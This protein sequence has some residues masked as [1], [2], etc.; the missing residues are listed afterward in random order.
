MLK[1]RK[2][3]II[4][5]LAIS[6]LCAGCQSAKKNETSSGTVSTESTAER[7]V[8]ITYSEDEL[9]QLKEDG[10][11]DEE[12]TEL[13][14]LNW[15][16]ED[17]EAIEAVSEEKEEDEWGEA[18]S[19]ANSMLSD[20]NLDIAI[21]ENNGKFCYQ[22][23]DIIQGFHVELAA[24]LAEYMESAFEIHMNASSGEC[25]QSSDI[26]C[27]L[28]NS[29]EKEKG[30]SY[31]ELYKTSQGE[32][33]QCAVKKDQEELIDGIKAAVEKMKAD[34]IY[35]ELEESYLR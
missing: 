15:D 33:V 3:M 21:V 9:K 28:I 6:M 30:Y 27:I 11:T 34:D 14:Q 2:K 32:S 10:L 18:E 4:A 5:V 24:I 16:L 13:D 35:K 7:E 29:P 23:D 22:E 1:N 17:A 31:I 26:D 20:M 12:I 8:K 25:Y 19:V